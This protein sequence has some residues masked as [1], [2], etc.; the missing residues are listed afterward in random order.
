M[1]YV[2]KIRDERE[3]CKDQKGTLYLFGWYR[4]MNENYAYLLIKGKNSWFHYN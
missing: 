1:E 3:V 2:Y 4:G